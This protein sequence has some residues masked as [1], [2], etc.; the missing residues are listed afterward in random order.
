MF[1]NIF[2]LMGAN[3][4]NSSYKAVT[5]HKFSLIRK[6]DIINHTN[7]EYML[8]TIDVYPF[9]QCMQIILTRSL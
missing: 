2:L 8:I 9:L 7:A 5:K 4:Q 6:L 1:T 3:K